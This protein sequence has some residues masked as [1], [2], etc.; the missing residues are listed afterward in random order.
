MS[1]NVYIHCGSPRAAS[2]LLQ[3][4]IIPRCVNHLALYKQPFQSSVTSREE[5]KA[6]PDITPL[7]IQNAIA[8]RSVQELNCILRR[9][10]INPSIVLSEFQAS[11]QHRD[12]LFLTLENLIFGSNNDLVI[13]SE[14]LI[15]TG[16]GLYGDPS[17]QSDGNTFPPVY[18]LAQA[19]REVGGTPHIC[20]VL[21][22]PIEHLVSIYAWTCMHREL[23]KKSSLTPTEFI[24]NQILLSKVTAESS[25]IGY[26]NHSF[27]LKSLQA[28]ALTRPLGF[29]SLLL[30]DDAFD[31]LGLQG[32]PCV[33]VGQFPAEHS[34][35]ISPE[36]KATTS[37]EIVSTLKEHGLL[38]PIREGKLFE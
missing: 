21:R 24:L 6:R 14:R 23:L 20:I 12:T 13:S 17:H 33:R 19:V 27:I 28:Y 1:H 25:A 10:I 31:L 16:A 26:V 36:L 22:D 5:E 34:I 3:K 2:T 9:N 18:A 4:H 38:D 35:K 30:S 7:D 29:K 11:T 32:E 15:Q 37:E 8:S